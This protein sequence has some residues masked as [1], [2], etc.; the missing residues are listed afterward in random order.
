MASSKRKGKEK[1]EQENLEK[2]TLTRR[3]LEEYKQNPSRRVLNRLLEINLGLIQSIV[4][5]SCPHPQFFDDV[6]QEAMI[7]FCKAVE[8]YDLSRN[9]KFSTYCAFYLRSAVFRWLNWH[10][11]SIRVPNPVVL[12]A[13]RVEQARE[14]YQKGKSRQP[15]RAELAELLGISEAVVEAREYAAKVRN[16]LSF[17]AM[18]EVTFERMEAQTAYRVEAEDH[19]EEEHLTEGQRQILAQLT[20]LE[21]EL[22]CQRYCDGR[23]FREISEDL[24]I[25]EKEAVRMAKEAMAKCRSY[26]NRQGVHESTGLSFAEEMEQLYE[27]SRMSPQGLG[28]TPESDEE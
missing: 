9:T 16:V 19:G 13:R 4:R 6:L 26:A 20:D 5:K 22:L 28:K 2:Q 12:G 7:N 14:V 1:K 27:R 25:G 3:L 15:T 8:A 21:W 10:S 11:Q 18:S 24:G 17:D 23:L